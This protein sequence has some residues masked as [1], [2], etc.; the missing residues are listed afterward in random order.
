MV[1]WLYPVELQVRWTN[2][3]TTTEVLQTL[4]YLAFGGLPRQMAE[5]CTARPPF[6]GRQ[7]PALI[8]EEL[9]ANHSQNGPK[10]EGYSL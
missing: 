8:A 1:L 9:A 10:L 7:A 4:R 6:T 2:E 3:L 5:S